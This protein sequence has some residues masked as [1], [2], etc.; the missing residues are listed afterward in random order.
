MGGGGGGGE[1]SAGKNA[2]FKLF[3]GVKLRTMC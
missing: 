3:G 1:E 2:W